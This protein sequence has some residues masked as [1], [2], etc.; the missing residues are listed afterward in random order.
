MKRKYIQID[1]PSC[2][3]GRMPVI[4]NRKSCNIPAWHMAFDINAN[5]FVLCHLSEWACGCYHCNI[6]FNGATKREAVEAFRLE[7]ETNVT[8]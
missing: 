6:V 7:V 5:S 8:G 3:C 2:L 1:I 4:E